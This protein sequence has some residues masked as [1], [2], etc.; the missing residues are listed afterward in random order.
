MFAAS[1]SLLLCSGMGYCMRTGEKS[2][3]ENFIAIRERRGLPKW[4]PHPG[5]LIRGDVIRWTEPV[6]HPS[7]I[8]RKSYP[9]HG[10][11]RVTAEVL[12]PLSDKRFLIA[13]IDE[14]ILVNRNGQ[15]LQPY[16][17]GVPIF[18]NRRTVVRGQPER[19]MWRDEPARARAMAKHL[20]VR[21]NKPVR[22]A[23][24]PVGRLET[25]A[26]QRRKT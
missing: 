20:A 13:V 4:I 9:A 8:R 1:K 26:K 11:R 2:F 6:W 7:P 22:L 12:A 18:K 24:V 16:P 23:K 19:L 25:F 17:R 14:K 5:L 10:L 21:Q 15:P 3:S